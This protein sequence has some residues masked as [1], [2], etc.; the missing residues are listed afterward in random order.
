[1]RP[2]PPRP[3]APYDVWM[4]DRCRRCA[5]AREL[6]LNLQVARLHHN[7][8]MSDECWGSEQFFL[9]RETEG[10]YGADIRILTSTVGSASATS[11]ASRRPV[12]SVNDPP[13][14]G[15]S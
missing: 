12:A 11:L 5:A 9:D 15:A 8:S 4:Q 13:A 2:S 7:G 6:H 14:E 1:M 10:G 3:R